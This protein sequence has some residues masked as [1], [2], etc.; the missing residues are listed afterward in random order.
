MSNPTFSAARNRAIEVACAMG[1]DKVTPIDPRAP[2]QELEAWVKG[3]YAI[4]VI[5]GQV[6]LREVTEAYAAELGVELPE[7]RL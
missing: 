6:E 7:I 3:R 4:A 2:R 5:L 1:H